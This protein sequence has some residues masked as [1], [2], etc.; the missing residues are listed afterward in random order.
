M[1]EN[2]E[3][4]Q[5]VRTLADARPG[6]RVLVH[7]ILGRNPPTGVT[8]YPDAGEGLF[9]THVRGDRITLERSDGSRLS[10]PRADARRI[11]IER[12][13]G[14]NEAAWYAR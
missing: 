9:C 7:S 3:V 11:R 2:L 5:G 10:I 12:V 14:R 4:P 8:A 6:M 1:N 13:E